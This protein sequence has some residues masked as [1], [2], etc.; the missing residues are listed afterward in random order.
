MKWTKFAEQDSQSHDWVKTKSSQLKKLKADIER[1]TKYLNNL[2]RPKALVVG[3]F[4]P[5]AELIVSAGLIVHMYDST[6]Q[7]MQ[8]GR[9]W[10]LNHRYNQ[11]DGQMKEIKQ[12]SS[13]DGAIS[14]L[15]KVQAVI[16]ERDNLL[17]Q[18]N[19]INRQLKDFTGLG[20]EDQ[21][22]TLIHE[23]QDLD[24]DVAFLQ[25]GL[26]DLTDLLPGE[27]QIK[28][29]TP[30][31]KM[32]KEIEEHSRVFC[33]LLRVS[34]ARFENANT[35]QHRN[36]VGICRL[37]LDAIERIER[38]FQEVEA[39]ERSMARLLARLAENER[40]L[41]E[42]ENTLKRGE[43]AWKSSND[44][45]IE[46][47]KRLGEE[48]AKMEKRM[49]NNR[50]GRMD[51]VNELRMEQVEKLE[52]KTPAKEEISHLAKQVHNILKTPSYFANI[53]L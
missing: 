8:E 4:T 11:L 16:K 5:T 17:E 50:S 21:L 38:K 37:G 24:G 35:D 3:N 41:V 19:R 27:P 23:H 39:S 33:N 29:G 26:D 40:L 9:R 13:E 28:K 6:N 51:G 20:S 42:R 22:K 10:L 43:E 49:K 12:L 53:T 31:S 34:S 48:E 25:K 15:T 32:L 18:N 2:P 30:P 14:L 45:L 52:K 44:H 46:R 1:K 7:E 36:V 47:E